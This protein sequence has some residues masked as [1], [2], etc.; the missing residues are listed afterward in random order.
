MGER[1]NRRNWET[2]KADNVGGAW[3]IKYPPQCLV[4]HVG[5]KSIS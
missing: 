1:K 2:V 5:K 4:I 3:V